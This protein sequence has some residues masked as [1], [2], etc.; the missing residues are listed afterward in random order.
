MENFDTIQTVIYSIITLLIL[1][2]LFWFVKD[3]T[4]RVESKFLRIIIFISVLFTNI[5]GFI[6]YL[7]LR[8]R[9]TSIEREERLIL[10]KRQEAILIIDN[11]VVCPSCSTLNKKEY[12]YCVHCGSNLEIRC[13]MCNFAIQPFWKYCPQCQKSINFD[14]PLEEISLKLNTKLN[15]R[16]FVFTFFYKVRDLAYRFK[17][18]IELFFLNLIVSTLV[19]LR[20]SYSLIESILKYIFEN[21]DIFKIGSKLNEAF[22]VADS[23]SNQNEIFPIVIGIDKTKTKKP[24][25][26]IETKLD[27][28]EQKR[29]NKKRRKRKK[30]K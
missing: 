26:E 18:L 14:L 9:E 3:L 23:K 19:I 17:N 15:K 27:K 24:K 13:F 5:L 7:V 21:L 22:F 28:L 10:E 4:S 2:I 25:A 30:K 12:T 11:L 29:L 16:N 6:F 20:T 1:L 8:P